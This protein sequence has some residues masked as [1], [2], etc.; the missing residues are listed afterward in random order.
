MNALDITEME[1]I[2]GGDR[3]DDAEKFI[4]T[5]GLVASIGASFGPIGLAIAGPTALG[6]GVAL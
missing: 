3:C 6:M 1:K 2:N 4:A 5:V